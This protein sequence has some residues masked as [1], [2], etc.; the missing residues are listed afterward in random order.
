MNPKKVSIAPAEVLLER[1]G[2]IAVITLNRPHRRNGL[3]VSMCAALYETVSQVAESDA[4]VVILRGAGDDFCVGADLHGGGTDGGEPTRLD[5]LG[6]IH[7]AA[8]LLHTMPQV[9]LAAID[10][11]C[12]GAGLGY[13]MACDLRVGTAR[14]RFNTAFLNVGVSGDMGLAWSLTQVV[15]PA[16]A[17]E[18]LF[19]P[20]KFSG[21]EAL[22]IGL[23]SRLYEPDALHE[24]ALAIA[25]R[26]CSFR[27]M[28]L[29][30]MKANLLSAEHLSIRDFVEV[31]TQ[32]HLSTSR[33]AGLG[34]QS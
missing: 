8:T 1:D 17:R 12:A 14:A 11:G 21:E 29:S 18:L 31:E 26:L 24:E 28:A 27:P 23:V 7:H 20:D 10:G 3:T 2:A 19:L 16:R 30:L 22:R 6:P 13:A 34:R 33:D 25:R 15:G 32:R 9:T 5:S 4:R